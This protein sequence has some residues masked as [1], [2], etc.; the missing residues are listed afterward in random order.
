MADKNPNLYAVPSLPGVDPN[1]TRVITDLA[2]RVN[3]LT[4]EIDRLRSDV[5]K[6]VAMKARKENPVQGI[7]TI[8]SPQGNGF[9]RVN[10]DGSIVS[11]GNPVRSG[12][13]D[14]IYLGENEA[15]TI[16]SS[17][18]NIRTVII[19]PGLHERHSHI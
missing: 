5:P 14:P 13:A 4:T 10:E 6:Q 11:Y 1:V 18:T 8:P 15:S 12:Y 17:E 3:Y 19:P 9:V 7:V 2:A 16:S